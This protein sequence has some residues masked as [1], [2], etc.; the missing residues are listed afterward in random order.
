[1]KTSLA[2][3]TTSRTSAKALLAALAAGAFLFSGC[4]RDD[5]SATGE[6]PGGL[7][8]T[9]EGRVQGDA[10]LSAMGKRSSLGGGVEGAAVTVLRIK[11][12]GSFETLSSAEVKTDVQGHF[13]VKTTL[14]GARELVVSARKDGK[15]WKAVVSGKVKQGSTVICRPLNIES[16]VEADVLAKVRATSAET[17]YAAVSFADIASHIDATVALKAKG[18]AQLEDWFAVQLLAEAKTRDS[19][20][21]SATGK[22]TQIQINQAAEA[23]LDA[24]AKLEADLAAA[25]DLSVGGTITA[26]ALAK[27]DSDCR[28]AELKAW[29]DAGITL[30]VVAKAGEASFHAAVD[31]GA[32]ASV[33]AGTRLIWLR[34]FALNS[35]V[36]AEAAVKADVA[37]AGG[38]SDSAV[39]LC[40]ALEASLHAAQTADGLD[41]A[42]AVFHG[43]LPIIIIS[44][45]SLKGQVEGNV[46]GADVQV[47]TVKADGSLEI[48]AGVSGKTDAQGGFSL[49]TDTKLPDSVVLVVT[50]NDSKLMI[51]VDSAT[52]KPVQVGVESTVEAQ[53][54]QQIIKD[55]KTTIVTQ[56]EIKAQIDSNV[57]ANVKGDDSAMV[58]L[59]AAMEIAAQAKAKFILDAGITASASGEDKARCLQ[60]Y[61]QALARFTVGLSAEATFAAIKSAHTQAALALREAAEA[62]LKACGATA[63]TVQSLAVAGTTLQASM[64]A[65][66]SVE[67]VSAAYESY[68]ATVTAC[69]KQALVLHAATVESLDAKI[70]GQDGARA[71]LIAKLKAA[72]DAEAAAKAH[73]EFSA[74]VDA[75]VKAAFGSGLGAPTAA[76]GQAVSQAMV[77]A[78]MCM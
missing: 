40:A 72:A 27:I 11:S 28:A 49:N 78:N 37:A 17:G 70:H 57:A 29:N 53:L 15:E 52:A 39:T 77:L 65:A 43:N 68:H 20:L 33:D 61:A 62:R 8:A 30:G 63:V 36:A 7:S 47:A 44:P 12:D 66:A 75:Q 25:I 14:D 3:P 13:S 55:G 26:N 50:K 2:N 45:F 10:D 22:A 71:A 9:I 16:S 5:S 21:I 73:A 41:S 42:F 67:A 60:V 74:E 51:L 48:L 76:Q 6:N 19:L 24:Q 4:F 32:Q 34:G 38:K 35:A 69:L 23:R 56:E 1:M 54:A 18:D 31:A 59:M 58:K 46:S 64:Q